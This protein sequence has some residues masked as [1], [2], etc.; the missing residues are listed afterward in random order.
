MPIKKK[1]K[2]K[3][4]RRSLPLGKG[5]AGKSKKA[6]GGRAARL[7]RAR[8]DAG[9]ERTRPS[10]RYSMSIIGEVL[11]LLRELEGLGIKPDGYNLISPWERSVF[12]PQPEPWAKPMLS[13]LQK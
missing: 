13:D 7:R 10:G 5:L 4:K 6:L 2:A 8:R 9:G 12:G 1:T 11:A 3:K